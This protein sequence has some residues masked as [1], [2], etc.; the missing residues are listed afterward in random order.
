LYLVD[1]VISRPEQVLETDRPFI[2][3]KSDSNYYQEIQDW[4][5]RNFQTAPKRTIIVDQIETCKQMT[6]NGIG[7]A[8]LPEITLNGVGESIFKIPLLDESG[9][10]LKRDT[11]LIGYESAFQL[12]Q[13]KAFIE[14]IKDNIE[15]FKL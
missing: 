8:I 9:T 3:F 6:I 14:V 4:W 13:V 2:Q 10:A 5:M 12:K 7:Y 11:W 1:T 15:N